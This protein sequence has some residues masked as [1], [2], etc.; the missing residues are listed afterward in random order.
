M[1]GRPISFPFGNARA[2]PRCP[3]AHTA[4]YVD[5]CTC[6]ETTNLPGKKV[7]DRLFYHRHPWLAR[8]LR[9]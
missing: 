8:C 2:N 3:Y 7:R 5:T 9:D 1:A 6:R 4:A